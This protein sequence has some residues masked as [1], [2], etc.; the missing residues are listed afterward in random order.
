MDSVLSQFQLTNR[1]ALVTGGARGLGRVMADALAEAGADVAITSRT[2][3]SAQDA[4]LELARATGRKG[5]GPDGAGRGRGGG[6]AWAWRRRWAG[7]A[8]SRGWSIKPKNRSAGST[9]SS[10]TPASTS[11]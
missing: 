6:R 11:A 9:S 8:T 7:R 5:R 10:T 3:A 1:R 2:I 4:P